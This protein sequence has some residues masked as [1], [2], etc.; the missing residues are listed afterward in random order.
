MD[1]TDT[2]YVSVD[3]YA[4]YVGKTPRTIWRWLEA[5]RIPGAF[6][7]DS[8][9]WYIPQ[10]P[11]PDPAPKAPV[12]RVPDM[13]DTPSTDVTVTTSAAVQVGP[14]GM[15]GTL[16]EAAA[17]LGTTVGGVRRMAD[18]GLL[19]VGRYGPHGGLRVYARPPGA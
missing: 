4:T 3:D 19:T 7:D 14:L 17:A 16:E 6:K 5:Q 11:P 15:L 2:T 9:R 18:D 8:G 13:P 12:R 1:T 10:A